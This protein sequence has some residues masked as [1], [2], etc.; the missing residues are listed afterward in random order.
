MLIGINLKLSH[1][2]GFG[3]GIEFPSVLRLE[4]GGGILLE[5]LG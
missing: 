1:F 2:G 3:G 5:D 4:D